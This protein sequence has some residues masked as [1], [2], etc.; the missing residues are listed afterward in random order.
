MTID[1]A[2]Y[3]SNNEIVITAHKSNG[4]QYD[5][6]IIADASRFGYT[7][8]DNRLYEVFEKYKVRDDFDS[9]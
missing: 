4:L 6:V 2:K 3:F 5:I 1:Q 9:K 7:H 8:P